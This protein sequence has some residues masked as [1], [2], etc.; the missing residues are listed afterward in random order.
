MMIVNGSG[1]SH[2][3]HMLTTDLSRL[4]V[5]ESRLKSIFELGL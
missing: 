4:V 3:L 2:E 5:L 1:L